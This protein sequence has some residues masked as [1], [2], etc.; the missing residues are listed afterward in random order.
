[1]ALT[2]AQAL[3]TLV[4]EVT[5]IAD[6][7]AAGDYDGGWAL[8]E[9]LVCN[10]LGGRHDGEWAPFENLVFDVDRNLEPANHGCTTIAGEIDWP[11]FAHRVVRFTERLRAKAEKAAVSATS[12][13]ARSKSA[14]SKRAK[15]KPAKSRSTKRGR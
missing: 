13:P 12:K 10:V 11:K 15:P 6:A 5:P 8:L 4:G 9:P 3:A 2:R 7:F 1:M 14:K